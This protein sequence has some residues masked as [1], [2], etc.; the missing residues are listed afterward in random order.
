MKSFIGVKPRLIKVHS[1]F[2]H[3]GIETDQMQWSLLKEGRYS[4]YKD[5]E[6]STVTAVT[7]KES[8]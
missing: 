3:K 5:H 7:R 2:K 1:K 6:M 4:T 8:E